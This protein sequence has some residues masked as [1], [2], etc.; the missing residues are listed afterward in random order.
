MVSAEL[1]TILQFVQQF[2]T[3]IFKDFWASRLL[4]LPVSNIENEVLTVV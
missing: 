1:F 2:V 3:V 4:Q